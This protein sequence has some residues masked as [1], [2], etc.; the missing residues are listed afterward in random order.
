M[1]KYSVEITDSAKTDLMKHF[2]SGDL[3]TKKNLD[4]FFLELSENPSE[5][6]GKPHELKYELSGCWS[7]S[8]NSKD[9]LIYTIDE[10]Q[11]NILIHSA[12]G[13]YKDK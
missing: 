6:K 5:G 10:E 7:R 8:I 3:K 2:K 9:R 12:I 1:G 11:Q 13:H 4:Q